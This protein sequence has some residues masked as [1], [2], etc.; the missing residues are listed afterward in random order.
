VS[1]EVARDNPVYAGK[2]PDL[3]VPIAMV[4]G[5]TVDKNEGWAAGTGCFI[6]YIGSDAGM[7]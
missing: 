2:A 1:A 4:A 7:E 3:K 6:I 5:E